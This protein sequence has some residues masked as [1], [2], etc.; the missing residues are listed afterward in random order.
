MHAIEWSTLVRPWE[1]GVWGIR[2][3]RPMGIWIP[4]C[5]RHAWIALSGLRHWEFA[6]V[7]YH[8]WRLDYL[9]YTLEAEDARRVGG[10]ASAIGVFI[11]C[12]AVW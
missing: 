12:L 4:E 10:V 9:L 11:H 2:T 1:V 7:L 3:S 8:A 5:S 6:G